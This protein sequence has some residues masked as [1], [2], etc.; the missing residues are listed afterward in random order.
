MCPGQLGQ[1]SRTP[2][3]TLPPARLLGQHG[4]ENMQE[5]RA[6]GGGSVGP[7]RKG[8]VSGWRGTGG[9][10]DGVE[11]TGRVMRCLGM[12]R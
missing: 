1:S 6:W 8:R 4:G 11:D 5:I 3:H 12:G 9:P 10:A 7:P 2:E